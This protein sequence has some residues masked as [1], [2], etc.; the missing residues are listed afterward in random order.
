MDKTVL[1]WIL[2]GVLGFGFALAVQMRV[3][4]ALVLRRALKAWRSDLEDRV[5]ANSAVVWAAGAKPLPESAKPWLNEA[6]AHLQATYPMPL[7]H[8]R[9]ARKYSVVLLVLLI[10]LIAIGRFGLGVI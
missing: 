7:H 1:F 3:M 5:K 9:R 10:F 6:V 2:F 8:L 4:V